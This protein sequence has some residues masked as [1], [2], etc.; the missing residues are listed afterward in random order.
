MGDPD[1]TNLDATLDWRPI[2][3]AFAFEDVG[4]EAAGQAPSAGGDAVLL[5]GD[6]RTG[7]F[8]T[9]LRLPRG[10]ITP[11]PESHAHDQ[12]E[13]LVQGELRFGDTLLRAPAYVR[14]A[15]GEVHGP[16]ETLTDCILVAFMA[17]PFDITYH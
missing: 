2:A 4:G 1:L 11:A 15:A 9:A 7:P 8:T 5:R 12:E 13:L 3:A 17:G 14:A 6:P 16:V 10:W